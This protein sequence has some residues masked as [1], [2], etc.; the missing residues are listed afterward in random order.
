MDIPSQ[1]YIE[2]PLLLELERIGGRG[3][4]R[5]LYLKVALHF[6]SLTQEDM[7]LTRKSTGANMWENNVDFARNK[8]RE[9]GDLDGGERGI[10]QITDSG[11]RRLRTELHGYGLAESAVEESLSS[12]QTLPQLLGPGWQPKILTPQLPPGPRPPKPPKTGGIPPQKRP[13]ETDI[14]SQLLTHLL[15]LTPTQ[16]EYLVG[17]FLEANGFQ[18]VRVTGRSHDGGIDGDCV[19]PFV[20]V[21]VA[22]QA[23]RFTENPVGTQLMQQFKG[24][25]GAYER[26][27]FITTS[28][29]TAGAREIAEGPGVEI[30]LVDG[31]ELVANMVQKELGIKVVPVTREEI[32]ED[33]FQELRS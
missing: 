16:F 6:P 11:R 18:E 33:F 19:I 17:A 23:K 28:S 32:D 5:E 10:W 13:M 26:G 20:D 24:S 1:R 14:S 15:N 25:I 2:L 21:K 22:F 9:K 7:Q 30:L 29:F 3:K 31:Q 4:G 12:S 8:L 27:V